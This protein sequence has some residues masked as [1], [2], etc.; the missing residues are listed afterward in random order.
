MKGK[1]TASTFNLFNLSHD[2]YSRTLSGLKPLFS[3][4][5]QIVRNSVDTLFLKMLHDYI[6][7]HI[8]K[9]SVAETTDLVRT[10]HAKLFS[11]FEAMPSE[12]ELRRLKGFIDA[13]LL[14]AMHES[15]DYDGDQI[16][17]SRRVEQACAELDDLDYLSPEMWCRL[18]ACAVYANQL[19][20]AS[21]IADRMLMRGIRSYDLYLVTALAQLLDRRFQEARDMLILASKFDDGICLAHLGAIISA[22]NA[23]VDEQAAQS[24]YVNEVPKRTYVV[25]DQHNGLLDLQ[26]I[27]ALSRLVSNEDVIVV[28]DHM[29]DD[30]RNRYDNRICSIETEHRVWQRYEGAHRNIRLVLKNDNNGIWIKSLTMGVRKALGAGVREVLTKVNGSWSSEIADLLTPSDRTIQLSFTT[31]AARYLDAYIP[32]KRVALLGVTMADLAQG[33]PIVMLNISRGLNGGPFTFSYI[34][35]HFD[36]NQI[37]YF[38][39]SGLVG[40]FADRASFIKFVRKNGLQ[41]DVLHFHS[42]HYSDHYKPFHSN[43]DKLGIKAWVDM[44]ASSGTKII[45][46]DHSNPTED[47]RRI[48]NH[49]GIDYAAFD[50]KDKE[51]FLRLHNLWNF[52]L[53]NW[54]RGW[55]AT[56]ILSRRQMMQIADH[57][58]HVSAT[59][60]MEQEQFILPNYKIDKKHAVVW[61]GTDMLSYRNLPHVQEQAEKLKFE[62]N[63]RSVLYVGR[64]E[65]EKGIFDLAAAAAKLRTQALPVNLIYAG[66]FPQNLRAEIDHISAQRN[67]Y[68]GVITNRVELATQYAAAD[69]VAQPTWGECFNQVV[70]EGL[71]MGTLSAISDISGPKEVYT[72]NGIALGHQPQSS[73]SLAQAIE[74][75]L[76]DNALRGNVLEKGQKFVEAR[77]SAE[78]MVAQY[79]SIYLA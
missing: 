8:V 9:E 31:K 62:R 47:L 65:K 46:T 72:N 5:E 66:N 75:G 78:K 4:T 23:I 56:S 79:M 48:K 35:N 60:Q 22:M 12:T 7:Q 32:T 25:A 21:E 64:A 51:H 67:I 27:D 77:L 59:Q 6:V 45:Y 54:Q 63:G 74:L 39:E 44:L 41:F 17:L 42:W 28:Q 15:L 1:I 71:A 16:L 37:E 55:D 11:D 57:V 18:A 33:V 58:T 69:L 3:K 61:N 73:D 10:H 38:D 29:N 50:D 20:K 19:E 30:F 52:S 49:H 53:E 70:S 40:K 76:T 26:I 2:N 24:P 43:R 14:K 68:T 34:T 13:L 36:S